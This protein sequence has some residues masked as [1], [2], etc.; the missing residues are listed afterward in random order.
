[1]S[2]EVTF[3]WLSDQFWAE[4]NGGVQR[5]ARNIIERAAIETR[6]SWKKAADEF[7]SP[8]RDRAHDYAIGFDDVVANGDTLEVVVGSADPLLRVIEYGSAHHE[9]HNYGKAAAEKATKGMLR[10][11]GRIDPFH[12]VTR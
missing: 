4:V 12:G 2:R 8:T 9:P 5:K 11:L 3:P 7:P 1:M 6:M 10:A